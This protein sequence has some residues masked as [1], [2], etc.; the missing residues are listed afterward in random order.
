MPEKTDRTG[1]YEFITADK[2]TT[3]IAYVY[4]DGSIYFP[5]GPTVVGEDDFTFASARGRVYRLVREEDVTA[6]AAALRAR[7]AELEASLAAD[8]LYR[9]VIATA[10]ADIHLADGEDRN[11]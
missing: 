1:W 7:I 5:E 2:A 3:H 8:D 10:V 11:R 9:H 4:E 6:E